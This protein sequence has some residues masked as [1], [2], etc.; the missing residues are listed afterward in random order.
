VSSAQ[1]I[2]CVSGLHHR[3][4]RAAQINV[5][6]SALVKVLLQDAE[7]KR[8]DKQQQGVT[9]KAAAKTTTQQGAKA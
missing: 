1:V 5:V 8:W 6:N 3:C 4:D 7:F 2:G 9:G